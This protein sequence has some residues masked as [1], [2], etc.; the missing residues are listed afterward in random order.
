M[1]EH[2]AGKRPTANTDYDTP[3]TANID[4][5]MSWFFESIRPNQN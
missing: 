1:S 2:L 4:A 5:H 3:A